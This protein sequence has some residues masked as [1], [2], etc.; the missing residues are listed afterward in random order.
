MG[1]CLDSGPLSHT[2]CLKLRLL[3][4]LPSSILAPTRG[5]FVKQIP[6]YHVTCGVQNMILIPEEFKVLVGWCK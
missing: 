2:C 3:L 6:L 4:V 5:V 1:S